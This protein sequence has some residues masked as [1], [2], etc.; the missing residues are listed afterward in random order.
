MR[1]EIDAHSPGHANEHRKV[2]FNFLS[3]LEES[4]KE[5]VAFLA[6]HPLFNFKDANDGGSVV[7]GWVYDIDTGKVSIILWIWNAERTKTD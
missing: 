3:D 1:A 7:T 5:D 6:S 4:V 2:N